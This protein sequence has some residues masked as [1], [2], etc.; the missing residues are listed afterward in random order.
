MQNLQEIDNI[1]DIDTTKIQ[2]HDKLLSDIWENDKL[3]PN[4]KKALDKIAENFIG[5]LKLS[6]NISVK[7]I[8]FTGSLANYNYN[9]ESDIDLHILIDYSDVEGDEDFV[10][11]YFI[12]KKNIWNDT[13]DLKI[14]GHDVE[15]YAQDFNEKHEATGIYSVMN[16]EWI[17][18]P[19]YNKPDFDRETIKKKTFDFMSKIDSIETD[20]S[21]S[22]EEKL[23]KLKVI[24]EKIKQYR[25]LGLDKKGEFSTENLVFKLLRNNGYLEKVSDLKTNL[26]V[27]NL[28]LQEKE[29][30]NENKVFIITETQYRNYINKKIKERIANE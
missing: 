16:D 23:N 6:E 27:K 15:L 13:Y 11:E 8:W 5:F 24:T 20:D 9:E 21:L 26:T 4:V 25:K 10:R 12:T 2:Y 14:F 18:K 28:S 7:D 30:I 1:N 17:K 19:E 3:K 22:D 29:K